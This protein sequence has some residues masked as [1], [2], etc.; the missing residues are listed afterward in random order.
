ML[1]VFVT[2]YWQFLLTRVM[3]GLA[4]G[5]AIFARTPAGM[6]QACIM[7]RVCKLSRAS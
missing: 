1:T 2:K 5:G 4:L 7:S 6:P 3:T